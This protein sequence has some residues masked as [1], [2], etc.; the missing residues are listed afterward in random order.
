MTGA[1]SDANAARGGIDRGSVFEAVHDDVPSIGVGPAEGLLND[2]VGAAGGPGGK[3]AAFPTV[4]EPLTEIFPPRGDFVD[5]GRP[6]SAGRPGPLEALPDDDGR[7][8]GGRALELFGSEPSEL[9][10]AKAGGESYHEAE[11]VHLPLALRGCC[12]EDPRGLLIGD[13]VALLL[14][15]AGCKTLDGAA[16]KDL[17]FSELAAF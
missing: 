5:L 14:R 11:L 2:L 3:E 10:V 8:P 12:C 9:L 13:G 7:R 17:A 6:Y 16:E 1:C 4:D 15:R